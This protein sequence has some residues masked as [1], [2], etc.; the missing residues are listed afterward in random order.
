[1]A[2][3]HSTHPPY[4]PTARREARD[5]IKAR[6]R[7][8]DI[9]ETWWARRFIGTLERFTELRRLARG[10]SYAR[11]G[12]VM[13]I[14]VRAGIARARV[15]GSR[16]RPYDVEIRL[17]PFSEEQWTCIE[18]KLAEASLSCA[19]LLA[20][21]MPREIESLLD[22]LGLSLFPSARKEVETTCSC[23]DWANPCKHLAATYYI[24]GERFDED[25]FLMLAWRGREREQL[26]GALRQLR[27]AG[28]AGT[29]SEATPL[30]ADP[31][32]ALALSRFFESPT[33]PAS[34]TFD[35]RP[36]L[37][38]HTLLRR[39]GPLPATSGI[40]DA[41]A[42]LAPACERISAAAQE[43]AFADGES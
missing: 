14:E 15:Q 29:G 13:G 12:Q 1:M 38:P 19:K 37:A 31:P 25:P 40:D 39:L 11:T 34:C 4:T 6:S 8:G 22:G 42:L 43:R 2:W 23:P 5:G 7:S 30:A 16:P 20:G 3:W 17:K 9:G 35:P 36:T 10:K 26:L 28:V 41:F 21:E 32:L 33:D 18:R 27:G 24:L